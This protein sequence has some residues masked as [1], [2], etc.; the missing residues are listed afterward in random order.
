M[1]G[2]ARNATAAAAAA[3]AGDPRAIRQLVSPASPRVGRPTIQATGAPTRAHATTRLRRSG[4]LHSAAAATPAPTSTA[5]EAP[6]AA[7]PSASTPADGATALTIEPP[8][9]SVQAGAEHP[10]QTDA[11]GGEAGRERRH[12][13]DDRGGGPHLPRGR[14]RQV[15]CTRDVREHRCEGDLPRLGCEDAEEEDGRQPARPSFAAAV[16]AARVGR[17][18]PRA[19]SE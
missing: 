8:T 12:A 16:A 18:A 9:S 13:C 11:A 1:R 7:W 19:C 5:Q 4:V 3:S 15:E 10:A 6:A 17:R 14:R 2:A